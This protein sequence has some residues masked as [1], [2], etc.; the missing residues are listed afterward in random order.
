MAGHM[1]EGR[2]TSRGSGLLV[3]AAAF[4]AAA[5]VVLGVAV[6][7]LPSREPAAGAAPESGASASELVRKD[8]ADYDWAELS[9]I[10]AMVA[11]AASDEEGISVAR[12][13]G[14]VDADGTPLAASIDV[15]LTDGTL[16]KAQLVGVRHDVQADGAACGL[17]FMLSVVADEPMEVADTTE[18]GWESSSLRAWAASDGK[19]LLPEEL[20][21][22]LVACAK[23]TN[24]VGVTDDAS[25]VTQTSDELWVFSASEV[26]GPVDWFAGEYG[27]TMSSYDELVG[28][29]GV[30]YPYFKAAGVTGDSD[31]SGTLALTYRGASWAWWYRT[32]YPYVFMGQGDSGSFFQVT[33]SGF[34]SSVGLA[35]SSSGVVL[36]FCI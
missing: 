17:T 10:S 30:Q 29:E 8:P 3:A 31:P 23:S 5:L 36:G 2:G 13:F 32:P 19:A 35:S 12:E 28:L 9:Q 11:G 26:C 18:G 4:L 7:R 27:P 21:G 24:N 20:S 1:R 15:P 33:A 34:P 25:S 22:R 16:A 14:L 6:W